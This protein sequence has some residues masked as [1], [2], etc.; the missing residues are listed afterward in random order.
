M[1]LPLEAARR[2]VLAHDRRQHVRAARCWEHD[3]THCALRVQA[4]GLGNL[5]Q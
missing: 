2:L 3:L 1:H 4:G 5:D